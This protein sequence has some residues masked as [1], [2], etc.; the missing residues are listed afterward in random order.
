MGL[1]RKAEGARIQRK[2][3]ARRLTRAAVERR[4]IYWPVGEQADLPEP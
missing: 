3:E 4:M 2:E 1:P